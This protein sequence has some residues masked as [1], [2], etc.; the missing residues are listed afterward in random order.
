M[1]AGAE[2]WEPETKLALRRNATAT[3]S[4]FAANNISQWLWSSLEQGQACDTTY[5]TLMPRLE[6]EIVAYIEPPIPRSIYGDFGRVYEVMRRL[7]SY[8]CDPSFV[9]DVGSSS[10][11]WSD[12]VT[13]VF[14]KARF[15]LVDPL[16]SRYAK[17]GGDHYMRANPRFEL[18]EAAVS[19][20]EG[21]MTFQVSEDLYGG[22]LLQPAD[23]RS[24]E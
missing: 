17:M 15:V 14:P 19:N 21:E 11:V 16:F 2:V 1:R 24:Y 3:A 6:S 10:G 4:S 20:V 8:G 9:L 7:K 5:E 13:K 12:T 23:F 18:V 22:S